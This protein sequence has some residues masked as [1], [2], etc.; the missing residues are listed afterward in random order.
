MSPSGWF[1]RLCRARGLVP[2]AVFRE[3]VQS[4]FRGGLKPPFNGPAR[5]AAGLPA[6]F[7]E[8]LAAD[9]PS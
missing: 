5:A 6:H 8:P 4:C 1:D 3:R 2:T 7:Y 9:W